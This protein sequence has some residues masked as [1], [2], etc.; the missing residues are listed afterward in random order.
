[1]KERLEES[2]K[3][4]PVLEKYMNQVQSLEQRLAD[5][6]SIFGELQM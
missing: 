5:R 6:D 2:D 1:M 3:D 4:L